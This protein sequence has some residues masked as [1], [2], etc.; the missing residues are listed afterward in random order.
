MKLM[1]K[2]PMKLVAVM[3]FS[4]AGCSA[5]STVSIQVGTFPTFMAVNQTTNRIYVSNQASNNISVIDGSSNSV[6]A[7]TPVGTS[8]RVVDVNS[9]TNT[10]YVANYID[11]T[12]SVID[13]NTNAVTAVITGLS[14]PYQAA[15][16]LLLIHS[17]L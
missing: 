2:V 6:I 13:G 9:V 7:T 5:S 8:P 12:V 17:Q 3:L 16:K 14:A 15:E 11:K 4:V 10:V 1:A